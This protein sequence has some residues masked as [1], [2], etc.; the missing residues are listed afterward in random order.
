MLGWLRRGAKPATFEQA[1]AARDAVVAVSL[2]RGPGGAWPGRWRPCPAAG[3]AAWPTW[4]VG[5]GGCPLRRPPGWK[6]TGSWSAR[7]TRRT[8][9]ASCSPCP[10][11]M[12]VTSDAV[13]GDPPVD[14]LPGRRAR[15]RPAWRLL[16]GHV[17][18]FRW[19]LLGGGL[20]GLLGGWPAW[21]S[22]WPPSWSST[23]SASTDP[24]R[25]GG[26]AHGAD[27]RRGAAQH[28]R[29]LPAGTHRDVVLTARERLISQLL[30]LRVG[31]WTGSSRATCWPG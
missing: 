19:T 4:C 30:R 24:G 9:S 23:P 12:A 10:E 17:S 18:P 15:R 14:V 8:T 27:H 1:K 31:R 29:D 25:P 2:L 28:R 6:P 7:I 13:H 5:A 26:A 16:L 11:P 20:L 3:C 22:R 21:P